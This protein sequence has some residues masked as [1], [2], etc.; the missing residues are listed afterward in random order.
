MGNN[1][2]S[3]GVANSRRTRLNAG[4][5]PSHHIEPREYEIVE[6]P[7]ANALRSRAED[8]AVAGES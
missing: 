1:E 8:D 5:T 4:W 6:G 2:H 3:G 7:V